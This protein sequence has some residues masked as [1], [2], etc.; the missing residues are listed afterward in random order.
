M[1]E[2]SI[3]DVA[4]ARSTPRLQAAGLAKTF[5]GRTVLRDV[6]MTIAP[7][8]LHGLIGQNGSG[9]S[10]LAKILSGYHAPDAGAS[11]AVDGR[12]LHVPVRLKDLREASVSIVYQDLGLIP[13]ASVVQNVRIGTMGRSRLTGRVDW[14]REGRAA[15]VTLDRLGFARSLK[16]PVEE[17]APADRARVA[18]ARALQ[19]HHPGRGLIVFDESTRALPLAALAD[20]YATMGQLLQDGTSILLIGHRLGEILEYCHRITVLRDGEP[21]ARGVETRGLS[22]GDLA[23]YMLGRS[24]AELDFSSR[25]P[26]PEPEPARVITARGV[27]GPGLAAPFSLELAPG[28]VVGLTGLPGSGFEDVPYLL[29]GARPATT[30]TLELAGTRLELASATVAAMVRRGVMLVPEDRLR[31]GLAAGHDV[32]DNVSLPWLTRHGRP[33]ASGGAWRLAQSVDVIER[34][35]VSP[36]DPRHRISALSGGNQQK[37]LLGKWLAGKPDLL[38]LHE[39]T[40]AVDVNARQDLLTA[41]NRVAAAGT[42]VLIASTEVADLSVLCDRV[43]VFR[44]GAVAETLGSRPTESSI[45]A[46]T[47]RKRPA[48]P[49]GVLEPSTLGPPSPRSAHRV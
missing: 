46:S 29:G 5:A 18:V 47:Y 3:A 41:I 36:A 2:S 31:D 23:R 27:S 24:L 21:V 28:E 38:L 12:P 7:G 44:D 34:L 39:P 37:V 33:W 19:D 43:L 25:A 20:F 8:E 14:R 9:K 26:E 4:Q 49:G 35:G 32:R 13:R 6:D 42:S 30:G 40:Q 17:L 16:T 10:T 48:D 11:I 15:Q 45:L 1:P 22:E